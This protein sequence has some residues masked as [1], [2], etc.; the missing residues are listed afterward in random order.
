MAWEAAATT[1]LDGETMDDDAY[2]GTTP[3]SAVSLNPGEGC[4]LEFEY[5][6]PA[7]PTDDCVVG[8]FVS[9]DGGTNWS[10]EPVMEFT[11]DS[12]TDPNAK[13]VFI[14]GWH[15]FRVTGKM[16]GTTDTTGTLTV[17]ARK[18]GISV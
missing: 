2:S 9:I 6:A 11:V 14:T 5:D 16:S 12:A 10:D 17:K 3:S 4:Q 8:V 15:T 18:D 1:I 7:S 13:P